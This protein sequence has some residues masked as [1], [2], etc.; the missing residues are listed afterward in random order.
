[1][2]KFYAKLEDRIQK[3]LDCLVEL[4]IAAAARSP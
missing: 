2:S 3:A 1:M 4:N